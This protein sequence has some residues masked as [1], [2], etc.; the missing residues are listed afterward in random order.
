MNIRATGQMLSQETFSYEQLLQSP[1]FS[2]R[3]YR[4]RP[5][6]RILT[7][8]PALFPAQM[9]FI[10][11]CPGQLERKEEKASVMNKRAAAF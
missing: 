3:F 4:L 8:N 9:Q 10:C 6:R 11:Y 2:R 7:A 5:Y 1:S